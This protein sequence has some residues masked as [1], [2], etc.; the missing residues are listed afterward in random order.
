MLILVVPVLLCLVSTPTLAQVGITLSSKDITCYEPHGSKIH[1]SRYFNNHLDA[2]VAKCIKCECLDKVVSCNPSGDCRDVPPILMNLVRKQA[3]QPA[4]NTMRSSIEPTTTTPTAFPSST[5]NAPMSSTASPKIVTRF[6][7]SP[8]KKY[9]PISFAPDN[10]VTL[11]PGETLPPEVVAQ[12]DLDEEGNPVSEEIDES[13]GYVHSARG[14]RDEHVDKAP[15]AIETKGPLSTTSKPLYIAPQ[16]TTITTTTRTTRP[17]SSTTTTP[18]PTTS[19]TTIASTTYPKSRVTFAS[20]KPPVEDSNL[21]IK[22]VENG[23]DLVH[24]VYI[25]GNRYI[26][27]PITSMEAVLADD[28]VILDKNYVE[29]GLFSFGLVALLIAVTIV[30]KTICIALVH[31][32]VKASAS[33]QNDSKRMRTQLDFGFDL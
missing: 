26:G 29:L 20:L 5:S 28:R 11:G 10:Q 7:I 23:I 16:S 33:D 19:T 2:D 4:S 6:T 32:C 8:N 31:I 14:D 21:L 17:A 30:V 3:S 13:R 27:H 18:A 12:D 1:L 15:K 22:D 9:E 24:P 25:H